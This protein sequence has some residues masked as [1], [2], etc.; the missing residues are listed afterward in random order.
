[1]VWHSDV[2]D[3]WALGSSLPQYWCQTYA[4]SFYAG[5]LEFL[6]YHQSFFNSL[7]PNK[8]VEISTYLYDGVTA[9]TNN[10][11]VQRIKE[12]LGF[13]RDDSNVQAKRQIDQADIVMYYSTTSFGGILGQAGTVELDN[14]G[15]YIIMPEISIT[16]GR[17]PLHETGHIWGARHEI[18]ADPEGTCNHAYRILG[19]LN[20]D[21]SNCTSVMWSIYNPSDLWTGFSNPNVLRGNQPRGS[22][23]DEYNASQISHGTCVTSG[24]SEDIPD[25]YSAVYLSFDA[26]CGDREEGESMRVTANVN[27]GS[28]LFIPTYT[29]AFST[30]VG[31]SIPDQP[32]PPASAFSAND[33]VDVTWNANNID[34]DLHV[35]VWVKSSDLD[36]V[37]WQPYLITVSDVCETEDIIFRSSL[38]V[39]EENRITLFPN[40]VIDG[41]YTTIHSNH[42]MLSYEVIDRMGKVIESQKLSEG[43]KRIDLN[44]GQPAYSEGLYFIRI[45]TQFKTI[46]KKFIVQ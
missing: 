11:N 20:D 28:Q 26:N 41:A 5:A 24:F 30:A 27:G 38:N 44:T 39:I 46:V 13:L 33:F 17:I 23:T 42:N 36:P 25:N 14:E 10:N 21:P 6:F 29:Y 35:R 8:Q 4:M 15:P 19:C 12:E 34:E 22:F 45:R 18:T 40:P 16:D 9:S 31:Q 32:I 7:V 37:T 43:Q 3:V 1:M 2:C